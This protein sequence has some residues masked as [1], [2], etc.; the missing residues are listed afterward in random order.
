MA[1]RALF[2]PPTPQRFID[3]TAAPTIRLQSRANHSCR[4]PTCPDEWI[5]SASLHTNARFNGLNCKCCTQSYFFHSPLWLSS[6]QWSSLSC[7]V[8]SCF[9]MRLEKTKIQQSEHCLVL[10]WLRLRL[11]QG[12][13]KYVSASCR[14]ES[15]ILCVQDQ[16]YQN[17]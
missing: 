3:L 8:I 9:T 6:C 2:W 10:V 16:L 5:H 7:A 1:P 4:K 17:L 12:L 11:E 14:R 15:V 13:Q